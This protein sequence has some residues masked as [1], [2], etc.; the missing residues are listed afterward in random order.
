[1]NRLTL[2]LAI[3]AIGLALLI[4]NHDSGQTLGMNNDDFGRLVALAALATLLSA[5]VLRGRQHFG[6]AMRLIAI[7]ILIILALVSAYVYRFELQSFGDRVLS[8]LIPGRTMVVTDSEDQVEVVLQKRI[9]GHFQADTTVNGEPV[10]MIVDT[11]ASSIALTYRDAERIGLDPE[12]LAYT[13]TVMT[14]NGPARAAPVV[15]SE[16]AIGP[17]VRRNVRA[18]VASEG[19]LDR[20]LL[21]MSFLSSLD[22]LQMRSDELRLRD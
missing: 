4:F 8:G 10:N 15:L 21:G 19:R 14:A 7:W 22:F 13:V 1:M 11:G 12:N 17:I 16:V 9:D 5:A 18:M 3:L 6:E 20:S 2:L